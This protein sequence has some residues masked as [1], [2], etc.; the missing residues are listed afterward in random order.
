MTATQTITALR[1]AG[2]NVSATDHGT[3]KL[4]PTPPPDLLDP[5]RAAKREIL[6]AL[7]RP[8]TVGLCGEAAGCDPD[9]F[10]WALPDGLV[11]IL[12]A[13]GRFCGWTLDPAWKREGLDEDWP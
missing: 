9:G 10:G 3:I 2:I 5:V 4:V 7:T 11:A 1:A 6:A 12:D 8:Y 13:A